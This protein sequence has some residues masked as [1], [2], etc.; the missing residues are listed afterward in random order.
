MNDSKLNA[1]VRAKKTEQTELG[2]LY[3]RI[4]KLALIKDMLQEPIRK[5]WLKKTYRCPECGEALKPR[6]LGDLFSLTY[7]MGYIYW[8]C[9]CGYEYAEE[10]NTDY[11]GW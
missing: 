5:G 1:I 7:G 11:D 8:H 2:K 3:K 4:R 10:I 9:L 6:G